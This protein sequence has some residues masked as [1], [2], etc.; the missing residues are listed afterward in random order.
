MYKWG[1]A[2]LANCECGASEYTADHII[3][4][5][6]IHRAPRGMFGL[7]VL[8]EETRCWL[9][10]LTVTFDPRSLVARVVKRLTLGLGPSICLGR[11]APPNDD[12][13]NDDDEFAKE[14]IMATR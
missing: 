5:C 10:S 9:K 12:D 11:D 2:P 8:D 7:M 14:T 1:L 13:D 6:L 3:S 4:Q